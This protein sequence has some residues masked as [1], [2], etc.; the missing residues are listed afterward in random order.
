[1]LHLMN[2][3]CM[4]AGFQ[5]TTFHELLLAV[6]HYATNPACW[7]L[8]AWNGICAIIQHPSVVVTQLR[9]TGAIWAL[10]YATSGTAII[11]GNFDQV[12]LSC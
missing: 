7:R 9:S 8:S 6:Y 3:S 12:L 1:M 5:H 10:Y 11:A 2:G 4:L